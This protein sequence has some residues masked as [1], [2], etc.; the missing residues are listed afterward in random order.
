MNQEALLSIRKAEVLVEAL[1]YIRAFAGKYFVIK[2]GGQAMVSEELMASV[3]VD[4]VLLKYIGVKPVLVHGGGKE[5]NQVMNKMG[6]VPS[7]VNG[8]RVTDDE[9]MEIVEMVLMGKVNQQ[10]VSLI[11][12]QGGKAVGL[13]GRDADL[14]QARRKERQ[15]VKGKPEAE[16]VD[17][18]R[19]GEITQVNPALIHTVSDN[20]YI[21]VIS[22]IGAGHK[23]ESLNINAD[24][25]AGEL[26][27]A[28]KAEKL[29]ILTDVEG[30]YSKKDGNLN[31]I[32]SISRKQIRDSIQDGQINGGM[33]PKVEACLLALDGGVL[34]THIIDGRVPHSLVLEIFTDAGVGTMVTQ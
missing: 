2:Y 15:P 8:L 30:V 13:S 21:P 5:V 25:V 7:F 16:A 9:T 27:V 10:I 23:G 12:Q 18:G 32:S 28:L 6:K 24:H 31:F 14:F 22:S 11:N 34:R 1:P 3:I 26:A 29:I 20:G 4:L 17:L 33:I 19:V